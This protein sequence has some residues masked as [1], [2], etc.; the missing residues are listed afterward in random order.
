MIVSLDKV[1]PNPFRN[2]ERYPYNEAKILTLQES[3]KE[4]GF[5]DNLLGRQVGEYFET[6]YGHHRLEALRR[7]YDKAHWHEVTFE[8]TIRPL[9]NAD[10][11]QIMARENM[12]E[13]GTNAW[14]EIETVRQTVVAFGRGLIELPAPHS[15]TS[16]NQMRN[17]PSFQYLDPREATP[18][19]HPYTAATLAPFIGYT[20]DKVKDTLSALELI[21]AGIVDDSQYAD[22]STFQALAVT[23]KAQQLRAAAKQRAA[24]AERES[25][26]SADA[27]RVAREQEA[28][29]KREAD[30]ARRK[31]Q[32]ERDEQLRRQ[33]EDNE[34][35]ARANYEAAQKAREAHEA[36]AARKKLEA[37]QA[38]EEGAT[39]ASEAA[40][41]TAD[42][43]RAG[44]SVKSVMARP[45]TDELTSHTVK[46]ADVVRRLMGE[47]DLAM[48]LNR[49][50]ENPHQAS[51]AARHAMEKELRGMA[52]K[53]IEWADKL[54][55]I[56]LDDELTVGE[57]VGS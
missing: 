57:L 51:P 26:Q 29:A 34:R 43:L 46:A 38:R 23:Q 45:Q 16:V 53:A 40:T 12:Q 54:A 5:W 6:A 25:T 36:E 37:E 18:P 48:F 9:T 13:W 49:L 41:E 20:L 4:T 35:A 33:H 56:A 17:A 44:A 28:K 7:T 11:L 32:E 55:A 10:M 21:E 50:I 1:K 2:I 30:E 47:S 8:M 27:A 42:A 19:D 39:A 52:L 3:I 24:Q 22:L 14:I 15:H 31:A